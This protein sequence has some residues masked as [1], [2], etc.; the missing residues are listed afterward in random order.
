MSGTYTDSSTIT[1]PVNVIFQTT[2]LETAKALCPYFAGTVPGEVQQHN[3]TFTA[4][5]R[6]IENL[7]P[8][9]TPLSF[10]NGRKA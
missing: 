8:T 6:R 3:G 10:R 4:A 9:T 2:L 5:W 7:T 1:K